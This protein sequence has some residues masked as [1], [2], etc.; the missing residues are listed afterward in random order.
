MS[1]SE[2]KYSFSHEDERKK[3]SKHAYAKRRSFAMNEQEISNIVKR[4]WSA[5]QLP[6]PIRRDMSV[7]ADSIKMTLDKANILI[8]K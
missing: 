8:E 6:P 2:A 7:S 1:T 4:Y 5:K 3:I